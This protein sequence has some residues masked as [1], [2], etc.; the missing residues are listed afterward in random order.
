VDTQ[1]VEQKFRSTDRIFVGSRDESV[2][3]VAGVAVVAIR[4]SIAAKPF[5][6]VARWRIHGP[7]ISSLIRKCDEKQNK[8]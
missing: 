3:A 1:Q 5:D 4:E 7:N 8:L 6:G 2:R